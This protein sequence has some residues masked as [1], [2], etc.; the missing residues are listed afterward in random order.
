MVIRRLL[1]AVLGA[2]VL[3]AAALPS[4]PAFAASSPYPHGAAGFDISW[5]QC[6]GPLPP[7]GKDGWFGIVGVND[8]RPN[9]M[10]PCFA[11]QFQWS[12]QK[13]SQA[14]IYLYMGNGQSLD[15]ARPCGIG[16]TACLSYNYGWVSAEYAFVMALADTAGASEDVPVWWLDVEEDSN[17]ND[18]KRLNALAVQG[19][20]DYLRNVQ[21]VQVGVY[22]V[23]FMW[24]EVVGRYAPAGVYNWIA[25]GLNRGDFGKCRE[26]LWPGAQVMMFQTLEDGAQYDIDR[27][28]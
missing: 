17:W 18:N 23:R 16:D 10:N 5:P 28:C 25:G 1:P 22:S 21:N 4:R 2:L 26:G 13:S 8:G 15:G 20:I 12:Q 27:G 11:R 24:S 14:G 6:E 9:T 19:A 7:I 3:F